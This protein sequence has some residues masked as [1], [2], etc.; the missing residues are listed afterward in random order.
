MENAIR[1]GV[2]KRAEGGIVS[3]HVYETEDEY[4]SEVK[5]NGVGF[6]PIEVGQDGANHVGLKNSITRLNYMINGSLEVDS[7]VGAGCRVAIHI[8]KDKS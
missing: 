2:M 4:I 3:I 5:D 6:D 7:A 8:P 1:H